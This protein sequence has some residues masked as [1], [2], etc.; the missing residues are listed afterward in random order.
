MKNKLCIYVC[1]SQT[2]KKNYVCALILV[3]FIVFSFCFICPH[4][5]SEK[6][7]YNSAQLKTNTQIIGNVKRIDYIDDDGKVTIAAELG[8]STKE[9][10]QTD[11]GELE[12]YYDDQGKPVQ[13]RYVG[14][15]AVLREKDNKGNTIKIQYLDNAGKPVIISDGY[16]EE[17]REINEYNQTIKTLYYDIIGQPVYTERYGYGKEYQYDE[18]GRISKITFLNSD[19]KPII[20]SQGYAMVIRYYQEDSQKNRTESEF[21]YDELG[22]PVSLSMNQF[23][24]YKEYDKNGQEIVLTY[25]DRDGKPINTK[26]GYASVIKTYHVN[27]QTASERYYDKVGNPYALSEGQYGIKIDNSNTIRY[28]DKDGNERVNIKNLLYSHSWIAILIAFIVIL[29]AVWIRRKYVFILFGLYVLSILYLTLVYRDKI[30][31]KQTEV[32]WSYRHVFIDS[33]ARADIIK[34]IWLFIPLGS[35]VYCIYPKRIIL[36]LPVLL[37]FVI[38]CIQLYAQIGFCELDDIINNSVGGY[39]GFHMGKLTDDFMQRIK[40]RRHIHTI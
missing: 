29:I 22:N 38:E 6:S 18:K 25:L 7:D 35:I 33:E 36:L 40:L 31:I 17:R 27:G 4:T 24:V 1:R 10:V 13:R 23:G 5:T 3:L 39:I 11:Q 20:T 28:I 30:N 2:K 34:N 8:Y 19:N 32:L 12:R 9:I 16:A 15:Y 37:S 26:K 14:Y 21:Y